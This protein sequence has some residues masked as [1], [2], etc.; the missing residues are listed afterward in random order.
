M[1]NE[2]GGCFFV[3]IRRLTIPSGPGIIPSSCHVP[4]GDVFELDGTEPL[5]IPLLLKVGAIK[6]KPAPDV[7]E[8]EPVTTEPVPTPEKRRAKRGGK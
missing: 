2:Y 3:A 7:M 4:A 5:N 8:P 1:P 6:A